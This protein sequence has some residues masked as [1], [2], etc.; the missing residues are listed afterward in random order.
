MRKSIDLNADLGE[1]ESPE[2]IAR[3]VAMMGIVSS[4]NIACG[5]HA[6]SPDLAA[7]MLGAAARHHV[8]A[9]AHPSYPDREN[10]GRVSMTIAPEHL[11]D[12]LHEQVQVLIDAARQ[13]AATITHIKPHGALYND[14]QDSEILSRI[15]ARLAG[16]FGLPLVGMAPSVIQNVA[17][18]QSIGFVAE[19]FVDRRYDNRARLVPRTEPGAVIADQNQRLAQGLAL[20]QGRSIKTANGLEMKIPADTLCLHSDSDGALETARSMRDELARN[21]IEILAHTP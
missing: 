21:G 7:R 2:G 8:S 15:L 3:D 5:G 18:D 9:G 13:T 1:D 12:S 14:A 20:A 16:E 19:A 4:C 6:G 17:D 10:F 11:A